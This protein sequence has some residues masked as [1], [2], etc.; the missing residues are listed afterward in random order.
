MTRRIPLLALAATTITAVAG[1]GPAAAVDETKPTACSGLTFK[2]ASGDSISDPTGLEIGLEGPGPANTDILSGWF[3]TR[4]GETTANIEIADLTTDIPPESPGGLW[5]Y[6][7]FNGGRYVRA[8]VQET[9]VT[10][11]FG[12]YDGETG[13]Y[14]NQGDTTG[15]LFEGPNGVV[16]IVVPADIAK[17][18]TKLAGPFAH[19]DFITGAD[20]QAGLNAPS[21]SGPDDKSPGKSYT[22]AECPAAG[23]P[24]P[25]DPGT[26]TGTGTDPGTGTGSDQ[27][28]GELPF[29]TATTLGKARK[30]KKGRKFTIKVASTQH[31]T[32]LVVSLYGKSGAGKPFMSG[33]LASLNGTAKMKL[34][35]ARKAKRG[36]YVL[37]ATGNVDG[38]ARSIVRRVRL[39]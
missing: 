17:P 29:R 13:V 33:K 36:K 15:K 31:L 9:G 28:T 22:V 26:G 24:A 30:A 18:G 35:V 38:Q 8:A 25:T 16:Q 37:K 11:K 27:G 7:E 34:K 6:M 21:D 5:Y 14:T 2:D 19:A 12:Q 4:N 39:K 32:D 3:N 23:A 20:D 1:S 10:Y